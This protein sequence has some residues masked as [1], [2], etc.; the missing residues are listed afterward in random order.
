MKS[1]RTKS[2]LITQCIITFLELGK[3]TWENQARRTKN[4][5]KI[6]KKKKVSEFS[7]IEIY[8]KIDQKYIRSLRYI[9]KNNQK[10]QQDQIRNIYKEITAQSNR[11]S[12]HSCSQINDIK[13]VKNLKTVTIVGNEYEML[14]CV[15]TKL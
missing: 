12:A 8:N 15:Y 9:H 1:S 3:L 10:Y 11:W 4:K 5:Q 6:S 2:L 13:K 7:C 14:Q